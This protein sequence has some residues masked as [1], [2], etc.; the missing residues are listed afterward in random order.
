MSNILEEI[1]QHK[2]REVAERKSAVPENVLEQS[3]LFNS[4]RFSLREFLLQE[5]SSG[6]IAEFKRKS[7]SRGIFNADADAGVVCSGYVKAGA[8]ALSILTD[9]KYFG[10]SADDLKAARKP[11][12]CPI[13]R[14]DF[15][16]DAYQITEAR[17]MGADVILLIAEMLTKEQG[18]QLAEKATALGLEVL[19]E[20]H[21][22]EQLEK[23]NDFVHL[24]GINNRDL[25]TFEVKIETSLEL[26]EQIP[27]QFVKVAESGIQNAETLLQLKDAGFNGFLIGESFMS[28]PDPVA[29]CAAFIQQVNH[30]EKAARWK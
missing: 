25:K 20:L 10:G 14:K 27:S 12:R 1:R 11:N 8:A 18:I 7:P 30:L 23:L 29:A 13:L 16:V 4:P 22:A 19:L 24:V 21:S 15:V 2:L 26:A 28:N 6:I 5:N 3:P 17:A 9:K